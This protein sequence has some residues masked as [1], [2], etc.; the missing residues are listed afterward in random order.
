M[1]ASRKSQP[2]GG[3]PADWAYAQRHPL[4]AKQ[5]SHRSIGDSRRLKA[6]RSRLRRRLKRLGKLVLPGRLEAPLG[7]PGPSPSCPG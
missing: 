6:A 3:A 2:S 7:H 5:G 1:D 4:A